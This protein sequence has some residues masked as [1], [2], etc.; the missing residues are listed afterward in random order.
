MSKP[1]DG[2]KAAYEDAQTQIANLKAATMREPTKPGFYWAKWM[3]V[4]DH[5]PDDLTAYRTW[6]PVEVY[7]TDYSE[8]TDELRVWLIGHAFN[9]RLDCFHWGDAIAAPVDQVAQIRADTRERE[10]KAAIARYQAMTPD[11]RE[12]WLQT[13]RR[14]A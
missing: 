6:E 10:R 5:L 7:L 13:Q 1:F 2:A 4:D 14:K 8:G 11:Q 3:I 12:E 9:Q